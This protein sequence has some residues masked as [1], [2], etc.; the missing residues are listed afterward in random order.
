MI[1]LYLGLLD[2]LSLLYGQ[3]LNCL[4]L[5]YGCLLQRKTFCDLKLNYNLRV[6][7]MP[8]LIELCHFLVYKEYSTIGTV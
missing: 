6:C 2:W 1:D 4:A 8:N 5:C 3:W 7:S